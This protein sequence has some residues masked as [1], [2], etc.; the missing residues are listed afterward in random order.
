MMT[1][2]EEVKV[3]FDLQLFSDGQGEAQD[4]PT[5]APTA[6]PAVAPTVTPAPEVAEEATNPFIIDG[7]DYSAQFGITRRDESESEPEPVQAEPEP[8]QA[9]SGYEPYV[10]APADDGVTIVTI[11]GQR[12]ALTN[13]QLVSLIKQ[14]QSVPQQPVP[15][16]QQQPQ[17]TPQEQQ[18]RELEYIT[19]LENLAMENIQNITGGNFDEFNRTHQ[20]A[21]AREVSRIE[22][23]VEKIQAAEAQKQQQQQQY[24]QQVVQTHQNFGEQMNKMSKRP[25]WAEVDKYIYDKASKLPAY[26]RNSLKAEVDNLQAGKMFDAANLLAFYED[27]LKEFEASKAIRPATTIQPTVQPKV[28]PPF[29]SAGS[30]VGVHS[31][32]GVKKE[33]TSRDVASMSDADF[34]TFMQEHAIKS[35]IV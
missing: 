25:D 5:V 4:A 18:N 7:I 15:Q 24:Q 28:Q 22:R 10:E 17:I 9:D 14:Q 30:S 12:V 3:Q 32:A 21:L 19:Q 2:Q 29:T 31:V 34:K 20:V 13:D 1:A 11:D 35:G 16:Q 6:V 26:Y 33:Y 27:T 8:V 23:E